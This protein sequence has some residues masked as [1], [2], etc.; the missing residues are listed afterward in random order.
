MSEKNNL[1]KK[2]QKQNDD[3]NIFIRKP[4][5]FLMKHNVSPNVLSYI[6]FFCSTLAGI[7]LGFGF[8]SKGIFLAWIPPFFIFFAGA[9]D[10]FDGAVARRMNRDN[11]SGAFLD[12]NLD[13]LSDA[14]IILGLVYANL[15]DFIIGYILLFLTLM[16]SY[17][18][19]RAETVGIE[20]KGIGIMGR[21]ERI[22]II[23]IALTIEGWIIQVY[24]WIEQNYSNIFFNIF[25]VLYLLLLTITLLHRIIH[26]FISLKNQN[27]PSK[28]FK[29]D[30]A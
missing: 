2:Q 19:A 25:V 14:I 28:S 13:R 30:N 29:E 5:Y 27:K 10:I 12:S 24:F 8:I 22:I 9:F 4:V 26:T 3:L 20:M 6:G 15:L 16:I 18:R 1:S 7:F 21:A 11:P 17:T 23:I